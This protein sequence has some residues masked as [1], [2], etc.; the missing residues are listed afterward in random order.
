MEKKTSSLIRSQLPPHFSD[1]GSFLPEF[2]KAYYEWAEQ[3]DGF[4]ASAKSLKEMFSSNKSPE[5]Y[6]KFLYEEFFSLLPKETVSDKRTMIQHAKEFFSARGTPASYD[7]LFKVLYGERVQ[8]SYPRDNIFKP[9][10][11]NWVIEQIIYVSTE[12][13]LPNT[14]KTGVLTNNNR[15]TFVSIQS[16]TSVEQNLYRLRIRTKTRFVTTL[17]TTIRLGNKEYPLSL[18][19]AK[20]TVLEKGRGFTVGQLIP[21][22]TDSGR[23]TTVKID[24]VGANG[25]I[26]FLS[27]VSFGFGYQTNFI[28]TIDPTIEQDITPLDPTFVISDDLDY[29]DNRQQGNTNIQDFGSIVKQDY[30]VNGYLLDETYVGELLATFS[31]ETKLQSS[32]ITDS[33]VSAPA[34]ILVEVG[35][36]GQLPGFY[37]DVVGFPSDFSFIQ[38]SDYYQEF[39]Y[40]ISGILQRQDYEQ[41]VYDTV[42]PAGYKMFTEYLIESNSA[43]DVVVE[44]LISILLITAADTVEAVDD[45]RVLYTKVASDSITTTETTSLDFIKDTFLDEANIL[46][47]AVIDSTKNLSDSSISEDAAIINTTKQLSDTVQSDDLFNSFVSK[48]LED[49]INNDDTGGLSSGEQYVGTPEDGDEF[50]RRYW[51]YEYFEG[52]VAFTN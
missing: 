11:A 51:E 36:I 23:G 40:V 20:I 37:T 27:L 28:Q 14:I 5:Q 6:L 19:T 29:E 13:V 25:R 49:D 46:D 33:A 38:D 32:T 9:S 12:D 34:S 8:I 16:I 17:E 45:F 2:L 4:L 18:T 42:H 21:I 26:E 7:F 1:L 44:T 10:D 50:A 30:V 48:S 35:F 41:A 15:K 31:N 22:T 24:R 52:E 39:S 43:L 3:Q 47:E